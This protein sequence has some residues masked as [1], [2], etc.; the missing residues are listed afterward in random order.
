MDE[1]VKISELPVASTI[2]S[3]DVA[4]IVQGGVT[5]QADVSL[6]R[7]SFLSSNIARVDPVGN[8]ATGTF[9]DS[10]KPFLTV[11]AAIDAIQALVPVPIQ[12]VID[13][14]A[15]SYSED[16]TTTLA[17]INFVGSG[18][19]G[20]NITDDESAPSAF[21]S[22]TAS[23][24]GSN[25]RLYLFNVGIG[26]D[27]SHQNIIS[28]KSLA[29]YLGPGAS[30]NDITLSSGKSVNILGQGTKYNIVTTGTI[31]A[32]G[33]AQ[34]QDI[35]ALNLVAGSS[36]VILL[37]TQ[38]RLLTSAAYAALTDSR[39]VTNNAGITPTYSDVMLN[40]SGMD[41]STLPT[42]QP[43]EAGKAWIDTTG[44]FNIVKVKL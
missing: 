24:S 3:P 8:D 11:Q 33:G 41:F 4:P 37:N 38:L 43:T 17:S 28:T 2:A 16:V 19:W 10:S 13:I 20:P 27:T 26:D 35:T 39:I 44:G 34:L 40:P 25:F 5:M 29:L 15:N 36:A 6:F 31:T 18:G 14:G 9:G 22:L 42:S 12:P 7:S 1:N 23:P 30:V 32:T 21:Q